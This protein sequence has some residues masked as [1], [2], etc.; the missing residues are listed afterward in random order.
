MDLVMSDCSGKNS[1]HQIGNS[2]IAGGI[3]TRTAQNEYFCTRQMQSLTG[4]VCLVSQAHEGD[5]TN[6]LQRFMCCAYESS[7]YTL[8]FELCTTVLSSSGVSLEFGCSQDC[9]WT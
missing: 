6:Q 3:F 2:I 8:R 5:G 4:A 9:I 7:R 1:T